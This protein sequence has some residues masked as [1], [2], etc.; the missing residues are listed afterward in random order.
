MEFSRMDEKNKPYYKQ[1]LDGYNYEKYH[2]DNKLHCC[3]SMDNLHGAVSYCHEDDNNVLWC[4]NSEYASAVN[5][6]PFCGV[7]SKTT[8]LKG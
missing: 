6:C 8:V 2:Q 5:F 3:D 7:K 1:L 4:G